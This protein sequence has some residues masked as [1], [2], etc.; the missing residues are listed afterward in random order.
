MDLRPTTNLVIPED[1]M[2]PADKQKSA[3]MY[4]Y[5]GG[6][7]GRSP[8]F[9]HR[10]WAS[11]LF[12]QIANDPKFG[13]DAQSMR[14][15]Q[16][17]LNQSALYS[18]LQI[19]KVMA[20]NDPHF[21]AS[22]PLFKMGTH[23]ITRAAKWLQLFMLGTARDK[24]DTPLGAD[25]QAQVTELQQQLGQ[26][27]GE[28]DIVKTRSFS[29]AQVISACRFLDAKGRIAFQQCVQGLRIVH[30][31]GFALIFLDVKISKEEAQQLTTTNWRE[32]R[33]MD[34]FPLLL[35]WAHA[36]YGYTM[37]ES[38]PLASF[39]ISKIARQIKTIPVSKGDARIN[40]YGI[41]ISPQGRPMYLPAELDQTLMYEDKYNAVGSRESGEFSLL[42]IDEG[43]KAQREGKDEKIV[44]PHNVPVLIDW[45]NNKYAYTN[46]NGF[47]TVQDLVR[48]RKAEIPH[49]VNL[50][51]E[52]ALDLS[53][54]ESFLNIGDH[55]NVGRQRFHVTDDDLK[56]IHEMDLREE[57][58]ATFEKNRNKSEGWFYACMAA[59]QDEYDQN[60]I[61]YARFQTNGLPYMRPLAR[62]LGLICTAVGDNLEAVYSKFSVSGTANRYAWLLL[63]AKYADKLTELRTVDNQMRSAA[64]NQSVDPDWV[65]PAVPLLSTK[66]KIGLLPHQ[67]KVRNLLKDSPDFALLPVQAGGGKSPLLLTDI[68]Y[69]IKANRNEPYLVLCPGHLVPNY[70]REVVYF[71]DG[72][73]NVI[74]ITTYVIQTTGWERLQAMIEN[75]PRNSVVVVD[76]DVLPYQPK[77]KASYVCYGTT[78]T[79]L[80]PVIDFLRQFRFGYVALDESHKVKN[81]SART[82]AVA[83]LIT[84]IPKKRL[85]SG[86]MVH[87][88]PTDLAT[89]VG[90]CDPTLF[91]TRDEFN[92][93]YGEKVSGNKVT[94]WK[95]GYAQAINAK[96]R[97]RV[98]VAGAMRKEWAALL[99]PSVSNL[100]GVDLSNE[101]RKVYDLILAETI[102]EIEEAAKTNPA[103]A[104][105]LGR[106]PEVAE[107]AESEE[108][109]AV[110]EDEGEDVASALQPYLARLEAYTCAPGTDELGKRLLSGDDLL[111]PKVRKAI[112]RLRLHFHGGIEKVTDSNGDTSEVQREPQQGKVLIFT[113]Y[114][115]SVDAIWDAMPEDLKAIG[116]KYSSTTKVEDNAQFENNPNV[117]WMVGI[118]QSMNEGLN[119]QFATRLIRMEGVW[120]PGTLEQGN[121]RINRPEL[122]KNIKREILYYDWIMANHTIDITKMSRL[123]SKVVAV[124]KFENVDN[125]DYQNIAS[126]PI[127][128]M[129][130]DT[131]R[132]QNSWDSLME[133]GLAYA[134]YQKAQRKEFR[135]YRENYRQIFGRDPEL[136][137][138]EVEVTPKDAKLMARVPYTPGL[139]LYNEDE[140]GL[141]RLDLYMKLPEVM[142]QVYSDLSPE[143][144]DIVRRDAMVE[145]LK[146]KM[147]HTEFGDGKLRSITFR[148]RKIPRRVTIGLSSGMKA[149]VMV[150]SAFVITRGETSTKDVRNH[151]LRQLGD[152]QIADE[153]DVPAAALEVDRSAAR[154]QRLRDKEQAREERESQKQVKEKVVREKVKPEESAT[155]AE[156]HFTIANGFLGISYSPDGEVDPVVG[157]MLQQ[158]GF[159]VDP[160]FVY[161]EMRNAKMLVNQ[162]NKWR[163]AGFK[164]D[165]IMIKQ[166]V[167]AAIEE[168]SIM[169]QGNKFKNSQTYKFSRGNDLKN[170]YR[171][172]H[173]ASSDKMAIKPYPMIENGEAFLVLP[174]HGQP[175]TRNA[176]KYRAAGVHWMQNEP[177]LS[178]F[179]N[180]RQVIAQKLNEI[181]EMGIQISNIKDLKKQWTKIK[182]VRL[183]FRE[184]EKGI[185]NEL[186][187]MASRF[188]M[189]EDDE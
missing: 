103:L 30:K 100:F 76:Y 153:V 69:E 83:E 178:F 10:I 58:K 44:L 99:P 56:A 182:P 77:D 45:V 54:F 43:A 27:P 19:K 128:K 134:G 71:T 152:L 172:E 37:K 61:P 146:E 156:F 183:K 140:L 186:K 13:K 184:D 95:P 174:L 135:E 147:F 5:N 14:K 175:A 47:L 88:S 24:T 85:A 8:E 180:N 149:Q 131:I 75:A 108:E 79:D 20:G 7:V 68:L 78:P 92:N 165:P 32:I 101:Q 73:L 66:N 116:L 173:K 29:G 28:G 91:G 127:I 60:L 67:E 148:H 170:F 42:D 15:G 164:L 157:S 6:Y 118:E 25:T 150:S 86:T 87:D 35:S 109:A 139:A 155:I 125:E 132:E 65:P 57:L 123:I 90:M 162:F 105:L 38:P 31:G 41:S 89:Q 33:N 137:P 11:V 82:R 3:F 181:M 122:K 113:N 133:Y 126:V 160:D 154:E 124:A 51:Q 121:S 63:V 46:T 26:V 39:S 4:L 111:S 166:G 36:A 72:R 163:E 169:L 110:D 176:I 136:K 107:D 168:L 97:S 93:K 129:S 141:I 49:I 142:K 138:L 81:D 187:L 84:D 104:K 98:V 62:L 144:D 158:I 23:N 80:Y 151:V 17:E 167:A 179:G 171:L 120:N 64:I 55:L 112:E 59:Y 21:I 18:Y 70:V 22:L 53:T 177:G 9:F 74:P 12:P 16:N 188:Y 94:R 48:F 52:R 143:A 117:K 159:R 185:G 114:H 2:L 161:A 115:P 96:I 145:H 119:F 50:L 130:L 102:E 1:L 189:E 34:L 106:K 40:E